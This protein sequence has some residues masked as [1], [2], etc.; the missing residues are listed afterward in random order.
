MPIL[1]GRFLLLLA[2][3]GL[4][5]CAAAPTVPRPQAPEIPAGGTGVSGWVLDSKGYPAPRTFVYAYRSDR[6]GFRGPADFGVRVEPDGSF[7]LDLVEGKY[8]LVA[9]QRSGDGDAGP[10]RP[11]DGWAVYPGNPVELQHGQVQVAEFALLGVTQPM[12]LKQGSLTSGDT[13]FTGRLVDE[14][15]QPLAGAFVLAYS[16]R[17]FHRVPDHTSLAVGGDGVFT[18][19]LPD[20]GLFCLAARTRTRG[21]PLE[22]EPYGLL[23]QG[24]EGCRQV[25]EGRIIDVGSIVLRP[26]HR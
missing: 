11:G 2:L 12:L 14:K 7:F 3:L 18:L 17:D 13:G 19:Y 8:F 1:Q 4:C 15:G 20:S 21:Q 26:F 23:G 16:D 6:G 9:R 22:G 5:A 10:L 24:E 25:Q